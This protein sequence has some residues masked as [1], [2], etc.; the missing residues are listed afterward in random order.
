MGIIHGNIKKV[1]NVMDESYDNVSNCA[2][3]GNDHEDVLMKELVV[4]IIIDGNEYTH[5]Y[6]CPDT[7]D[8]IYL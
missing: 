7:G 3:C 1:N 4:P 2:S 8:S 6:Y 5:M